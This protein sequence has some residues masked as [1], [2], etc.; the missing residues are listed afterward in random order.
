MTVC[1]RCG[2]GEASRV[3]SRAASLCDDC[4]AIELFHDVLHDAIRRCEQC[5]AVVVDGID[6]CYELAAVSCEA[7]Y[8]A[9]CD[10]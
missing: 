1:Q 10:A 6:A 2:S 8:L 3:P 5:Q 7:C 9:R 4:I